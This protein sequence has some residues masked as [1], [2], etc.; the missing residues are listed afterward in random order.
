[1]LK[2]QVA[3]GESRQDRHPDAGEREMKKKTA[4]ATSTREMELR[5]DR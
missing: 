1:M 4:G 5:H 2:R 3:R